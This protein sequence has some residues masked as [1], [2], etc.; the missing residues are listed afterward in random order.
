MQYKDAVAAG[1]RY[2]PGGYSCRCCRPKLNKAQVHQ[3]I[4]KHEKKQLRKIELTY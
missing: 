4:R 3:K 1:I 2:G